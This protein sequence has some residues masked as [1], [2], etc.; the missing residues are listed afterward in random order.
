MTAP[1]EMHED[2]VYQAVFYTVYNFMIIL[3][4]LI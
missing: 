3:P 1:D 4:N 2:T